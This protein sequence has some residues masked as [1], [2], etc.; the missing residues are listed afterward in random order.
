MLQTRLKWRSQE[1]TRGSNSAVVPLFAKAQERGAHICSSG[2]FALLE[3]FPQILPW[4][5]LERSQ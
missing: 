5:L 1:D 3:R 2:E 4:N